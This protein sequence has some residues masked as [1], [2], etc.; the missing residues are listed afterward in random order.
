MK[1]YLHTLYCSL[2]TFPVLFITPIVVSAATINFNPPRVETVVDNE[3]LIDVLFSTEGEPINAL[4]GILEIATEHWDVKEIRDGA[5]FISLWIERPH[6][7]N[8]GTIHFSGV[9]P[10]GYSETEGHV[11]SLV[12]KAKTAG[13]SS[14]MLTDGRTILH[15]AAGTSRALSATLPFVIGAVASRDT[16]IIP[17]LEDV[18]PPELFTPRVIQ[19]ALLFDGAWVLVF[20]AEDTQSGIDHFEV[21]EGE[22]MRLEDNAEWTRAESPYLLRDQS[23]Q[24]HIY[25]KAVDRKGNERVAV[26]ESLEKSSKVLWITI[27]FIIAGLII[28][29]KKEGVRHALLR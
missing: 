14:I 25:V 19:D 3:V 10:G 29:W 28:F 22:E 8:E 24:S 20:M 18:E 11:M 6:V 1:S 16:V 9:V 15:D 21:Y 5:S 13:N 7:S 12:L 27:A 4:E 2:Y 23:R 26:V 17:A